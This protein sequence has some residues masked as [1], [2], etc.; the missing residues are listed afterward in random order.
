M[1]SLILNCRH[2]RFRGLS[3]GF[4]LYVKALEVGQIPAGD[5]QD[6]SKGSND[7]PGPRMVREREIFLRAAIQLLDKSAQ[8]IPPNNSFAVTQS[9]I[10][11]VQDSFRYGV[12]RKAT[13]AGSL[14]GI[15]KRTLTPVWT[16]KLVFL[17]YGIFCYSDQLEDRSTKRKVI[18]LSSNRCY[19]RPITLPCTDENRVFELTEYGG[20]RRLWLTSSE[21]E[22]DEWVAAIRASMT[23]NVNTEA[24]GDN[25]NIKLDFDLSQLQAPPLGEYSSNPCCG[26]TELSSNYQDSSSNSSSTTTTAETTVVG[27]AAWYTADIC[28]YHT[29]K[30]VFENMQSPDEFVQVVDKMR[31]GGISLR[32]PVFYIKVRMGG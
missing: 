14:V 22:R 24:D 3:N 30:R 11:V 32:M 5:D 18:E 4:E 2:V 27:A 29:L 8:K 1:L 17:R 9:H 20:A 10:D 6:I 28:I 12:L 7:L 21:R 16:S 25:T 15:A 19:C 13:R 26:Q 31:D 23:R